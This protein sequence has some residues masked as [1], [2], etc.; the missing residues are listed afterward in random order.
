MYFIDKK[1]VEDFD[2]RMVLYVKH[3]SFFY[4]RREMDTY[5]LYARYLCARDDRVSCIQ[6]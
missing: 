1:R 3:E 4:V 2:F 5:T 6:S